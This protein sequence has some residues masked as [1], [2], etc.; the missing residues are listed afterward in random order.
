MSKPTESVILKKAA[1]YFVP[2]NEAVIPDIFK[3][4][5]SEVF[6]GFAAHSAVSDYIKTNG[7]WIGGSIILSQNSLVFKANQANAVL[8]KGNKLA[9]II[10]LEDIRILHFEK[11]FGSSIITAESEEGM[12]SFRC[13]G[14]KKFL[15]T[16]SGHA[17][18][19]K[20][21]GI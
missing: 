3:F 2:A 8:N 18:Q 5:A 15:Q 1:N 9:D 14:A 19:A 20:I 4:F 10:L 7:L 11:A 6:D 21:I 13:F 16:L 17:A 12:L